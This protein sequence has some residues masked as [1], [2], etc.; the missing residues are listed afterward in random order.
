RGSGTHFSR[1]PRA[2]EKCVPRP[3][4]AKFLSAK[5]NLAH[6]S[7]HTSPKRVKKCVQL[8]SLIPPGLWCGPPAVIQ[9]R[10]APAM[11]EQEA[12]CVRLPYCLGRQPDGRYVVLN[13]NY[14]PFGF[15]TDDFVDYANYPV[16]VS[17]KVTPHGAR[18]L[19]C[20]GRDCVPAHSAAAMEAY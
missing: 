8:L 2:R 14:K 5:Q 4:S 1:P 13:R 6:N 18:T 16:A 20:H 3:R 9:H 10:G 7:A 15:L 12:R 17:L 19:S 11:I